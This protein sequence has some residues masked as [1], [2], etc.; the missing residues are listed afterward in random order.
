MSVRRG[1]WRSWEQDDDELDGE[2]VDVDEHVARRRDPLD[3]DEVDYGRSTIWDG[4]AEDELARD[5][6]SRRDDQGVWV[7]NE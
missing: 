5:G 7:P 1:N 2:P 3:V 6:R 4:R